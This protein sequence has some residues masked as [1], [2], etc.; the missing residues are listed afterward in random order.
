MKSF[1]LGFFLLGL[2]PVFHCYS[3]E[4]V[5]GR[6]SGLDTIHNAEVDWKFDPLKRSYSFY[7][8]MDGSFAMPAD[9]PTGSFT[10]SEAT[11]DCLGYLLESSIVDL[12][13]PKTRDILLI[14][15]K[16]KQDRIKILVLDRASGDPIP[17]IQ[18]HLKGH[19][20]GDY[21][22]FSTN[23]KGEIDMLLP[24][25]DS[26]MDITVSA[27]GYLGLKECAI[28]V[29]NKTNVEISLQPLELNTPLILDPVNFQ[30]KG[31]DLLTSTCEAL[32][33]LADQ[34]S[35]N[36]DLQINLKSHVASRR[37]FY[38]NQRISERHSR[39]VVAYLMEKGVEGDRINSISYGKSYPLI[40]CGGSC[41]EDEYKTNSRME[42][43]F[44]RGDFRYEPYSYPR[45]DIEG[46]VVVDSGANITVIGPTPWP[47]APDMY[48]VKITN[49]DSHKAG[50]II[51]VG[52]EVSP[53]Y[54]LVAGSFGDLQLAYSLANY[55]R[56]NYTGEVYLIPPSEGQSR[57]LVALDRYDNLEEAAKGMREFRRK[58][59]NDNLWIFY[60]DHL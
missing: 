26:L 45:F 46:E 40:E 42:V 11:S 55:F 12:G 6:E 59:H 30:N 32:D 21:T 37:S 41:S 34:L 24:S 44:F 50:Q 36:P 10:Q 47:I 5:K 28:P 33:N 16:E 15:R 48:K 31:R 8:E 17:R 52:S 54:Y 49:A 38:Y 39:A 56:R 53:F 2:M 57:F 29:W 43:T 1:S 4:A 20:T 25:A 35:L 22:G 3:S 60:S 51:N 18:I 27:S 9:G 58:I 13:I 14:K 23:G 7:M 19:K